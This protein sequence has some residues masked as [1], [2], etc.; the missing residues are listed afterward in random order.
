MIRNIKTNNIFNI[1]EIPK[2][3]EPNKC[4]VLIKKNY[5]NIY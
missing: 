2:S 3:M 1:I 4:N 5:E